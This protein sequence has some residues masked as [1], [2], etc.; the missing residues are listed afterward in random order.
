MPRRT[1]AGFER[2]AIEHKSF[3]SMR[4]HYENKASETQLIQKSQ[5]EGMRV[6]ILSGVSG[7]RQAD[8]TRR[9]V[10]RD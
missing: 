5:L 6:K 7:I 1:L 3:L 8:A 9:P 10:P 4:N 2:A